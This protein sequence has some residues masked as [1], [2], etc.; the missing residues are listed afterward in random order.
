MPQFKSGWRLQKKR[1]LLCNALFFNEINP[2]R[3]LWNALRAWNTPAACEIAAA[4]R[5]LFHFTWREASNIT[6][7]EVNYFTSKCSEIFHFFTSFKVKK[8]FR[9]FTL[10]VCATVFC[11][12]FAA[13]FNEINPFRDLWNALR[14]WNTPAAC[15]IAAAVRDLFHF[16]W[17][18]ASNITIHEVNYFTASLASDFTFY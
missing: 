6:I 18:E 4:V 14:A 10:A 1:A 8:S 17:R 3:D 12:L 5:D 13:F 7:H 11:T 15:E 9:V 16:T 2:F